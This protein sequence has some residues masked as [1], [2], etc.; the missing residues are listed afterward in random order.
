MQ[1]I[2]SK[3][4]EGGCLQDDPHGWAGGAG[5]QLVSWGAHLRCK[6]S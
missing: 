3:T 1:K 4:I 2:T 5:S 6:V